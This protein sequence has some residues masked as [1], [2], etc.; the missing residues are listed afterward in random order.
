MILL[1]A[2]NQVSSNKPVFC[3]IYHQYSAEYQAK[4]AKQMAEL[5][6][7]GGFNETLGMI[8]DFGETRKSILICKKVYGNEKD[9]KR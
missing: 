9:E 2:C 6:S 7:K 5:K 4:V 3:G 1:T 8:K